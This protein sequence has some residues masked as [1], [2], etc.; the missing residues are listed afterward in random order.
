MSSRIFR[1][2][3][4]LSL[5]AGL[6]PAGAGAAD[7]FPTHSVRLIAPYTAGGTVDAVA[8]LVAQQLTQMW[9][10][11][12]VVENRDG[13]GGNLG[14]DL[15]AKSK[16][17]G[18]TL[19]INT[20]AIVIAPSV[21]KTLPF[22][23]LKDLAPVIDLGVT[24]AILSASPTLEANTAGELVAYAKAH[25]GKLNF[26]SP[27]TGTSLHLAGELFKSMA[28]IDMVHVPYKGT[29]PAII[30]VMAGQIQLLFDPV[31][32][33]QPFLAAGK[34]KAL[35]VSTLKRSALV[36]QIPT[37]SESGVPGYDFSLWYGIFAAGATPA[38]VVAQINR[39]IVHVLSEGAVKEKMRTYGFDISG[40][41][42][43]EFA[44]EVV[45]DYKKWADVV[46]SV[47]LEKKM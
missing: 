12:V 39:D 4:W 3:V 2:L 9:H 44:S 15:V 7:S 40:N 1:S 47:G 30:D 28:K 13:A 18:Y 20:P 17:D 31:T 8:R 26:G 41:S 6:Y 33:A 27:G 16:P 42:P 22:D 36:P 10:Q 35:G 29:Q 21:Y 24:P 23:P 43:K 5:C 38:A 46:K 19:L 14:S 45:A 11:S 32:E 34:I 25:P 37:I